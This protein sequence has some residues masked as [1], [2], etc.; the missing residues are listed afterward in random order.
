MHNAQVTL[1][2]RAH[3]RASK[4]EV[5]VSKRTKWKLVHVYVPLAINVL[6]ALAKACGG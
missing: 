5:P 1:K 2:L 4:L 3:Q 6:L